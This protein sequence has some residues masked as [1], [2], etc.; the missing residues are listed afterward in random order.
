MSMN[1]MG[2][3]K[4]NDRNRQCKFRTKKARGRKKENRRRIFNFLVVEINELSISVHIK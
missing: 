1:K 2:G 3:N 4:Q